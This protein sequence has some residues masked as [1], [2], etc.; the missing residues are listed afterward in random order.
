MSVK[1]V[2]F[3]KDGTVLDFDAFWLPVAV[4]ATKIIMSKLGVIDVPSA[5]VLKSM[6]VVDGIASIKGSLCCGT[7][8]DM[9]EDMNS[10]FRKY[11]YNF[12]IEGLTELT[13]D[14][15]RDSIDAGEIKPTC[16]NIE[17]V[18]Q[19][20]K[21]RGIK[22]ILVTSDGPV[23]TGEC[24]KGLAIDKY[25]D[26]VFTD[27]G[28]HPNKPDPFMI[29]KLCEDYG[30]EKSEVVMVGDT[31]TDM[32]FA[33]NGGISAVGIAKSEENRVVLL[34]KTPTV[35]PDISHTLKVIQLI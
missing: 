8:R 30:F 14:A 13:I 9:A 16:D 5:A 15:Y 22:I 19:G 10:V 29:N 34:E 27:D 3:D 20:L 33:I 28:T 21:D 6:G 11:G 32:N 25:F 2:I 35:I 17:E 26:L 12:D 4:K 31:L 18:M 1:A 24:L 23:V 7:S